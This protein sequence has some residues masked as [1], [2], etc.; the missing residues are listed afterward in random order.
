MMLHSVARSESGGSPRRAAGTILQA[1]QS[2][3]NAGGSMNGVTVR[4]RVIQM[5]GA[6]KAENRTDDKHRPAGGFVE[7]I[8][9]RIDWQDG[10]LGRGEERIEPNGAFVE[11]VID[12][13]RQRIVSYQNSD[14]ACKENAAALIALENALANLRSRTAKR[15]ERDVE[16]THCDKL[17]K[18]YAEI[19]EERDN[20]QTKVDEQGDAI[21]D[22]EEKLEV[23]TDKVAELEK[24]IENAR[25]VIDDVINTLEDV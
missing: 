16:G 25:D 20:L 1:S 22:L 21:T 18:N 10:P 7:G 11:T 14:F 9:L 19:E 24:V 5:L 12:A 8:G 3:R 23:A 17:E 6:Y 15:E 4:R 2:V 13:A